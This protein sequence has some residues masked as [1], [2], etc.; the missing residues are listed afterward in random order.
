MTIAPNL[1]DYRFW[2]LTAALLSLSVVFFHPQTSAQVSL[3]RLVFVVDITRSMNTEDYQLDKQPVSRLQFVKQALRQELLKLPC[4]SQVG[5]GVFTERRSTLL[6]EPIDVCSG[7]AEIDAAIAAL[8]WRMAW[9]A[10]SRIA[11]G[12]LSTLEMLKDKDQTLVFVSDG[13]EA[14][15]PNPRYKPDLSPVKDKVKGVIVGVGGEQLSPI[16]KFDAKGQRQG[17]YKPEDVPHRSSF[18]ESDLNPEKIQ[19][20]NARNA[21]FGSEAATGDEHMSRLHESYLRQLAAESGLQYRRL[22]DTDS[23]DQALQQAEFAKPGKQNV[24]TGWRYAGLA[25]LL[26]A[27]V[28]VRP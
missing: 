4:G 9:A 14:P 24:D 3:Y 11:S 20:Y 23:L 16:P 7:F 18:G 10:D 1:R 25:L 19:G 12:L 5:L 13:Q 8:D 6:F 2:L 21:P 26:F 17:F 22:S 15:P 27:A 28:Y